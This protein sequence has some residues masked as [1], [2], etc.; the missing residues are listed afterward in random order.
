M[1]LFGGYSRLVCAK[2]PRS[3][4]EYSDLVGARVVVIQSPVCTH[5][6]SMDTLRDQA[7]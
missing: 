4:G 1:A 7:R 2:V 5:P 3:A 6:T